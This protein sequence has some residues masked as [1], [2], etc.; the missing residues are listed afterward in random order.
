MLEQ[1]R[2]QLA[3]F[4]RSIIPQGQAVLQAATASFQVGRSDFLMLLESQSML[5]DYETQ[6]HRLV[7]DFAQRLAELEQVVGRKVL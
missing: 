2:S 3:L 1:G 6:Y 4:K 7:T 5:Y